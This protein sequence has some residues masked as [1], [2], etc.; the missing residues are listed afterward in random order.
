VGSSSG[1]IPDLLGRTGL[2]VPEGDVE[3]LA[4][5][6]GRLADDPGLRAELGAK[7]RRRSVRLFSH[8]AVAETTRHAIEI[9]LG[10]RAE[11]PVAYC[12]VD[13]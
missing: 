5:A 1:A 7:A 11:R 6:L 13:D 12:D 2:I 4:A 10:R 3:A 9:G 8:E